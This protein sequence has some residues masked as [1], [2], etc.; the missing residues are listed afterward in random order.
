MAALK[1]NAQY[2]ADVL[3]FSQVQNSTT[4]RFN[5]LGGYKSSLG[6]DINS[7]YGNP[8]GLGMFSKSEFSITPSLKIRN[9]NITIED[10]SKSK[11]SSNI[12]LDNIGVV[13]HAINNKKGN[14]NK[15][16]ISLNFGIGYQKRNAFRNDFQYDLTT[17]ANGLGDFFSETATLENKTQANLNS[18]VNGAAYD[19]FLIEADATDA[20]IYVPN[21]STNSV[22]NQFIDRTGGS[23]NVDF[24]LGANISNTL[25]VGI[26]LGLSSFKYTSIEKTKELG[27]YRY[28][29]NDFDYDVDYYRNFDTEGSGLDLKLGMILRPISALR[30]GLSFESPTWFNV[31]DSYSE[32]LQNN[33]DDV[34]GTDYYPFDYNLRTPAKLNT[35]ISYFFGNKGFLTADIG[36]VDYSTIKFTST[37]SPTNLSTK[38]AVK[39]NYKNT[40]NYSI[41]GEFKIQPDFSLRL[42][43][44]FSGN[45]YKNLKNSD[46]EIEAYSAGLGYKFGPY[47]IDMALVNSDQ[48][49]YYSNYT[50]ANDTE[51]NA[52]IATKT[53]NISLTFGVKF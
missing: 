40:I 41:G 31:V 42:G 13:F 43:Y 28:N 21:T 12:D 2:L 37:D 4:A 49:L 38:T 3:R 15:G 27:L 8:A 10:K 18:L 20:T 23:S 39:Q 46:F 14:L 51:P 11:N 26:N 34:A 5:A 44:Q 47:Y 30:I 52:K 45:P 25:F 48:N 6:G 50:L 35:G 17:N 1:S 29:N 33:I 22:Q 53:N 16:L 36:F 19:S 24:S 32:Q 7:L 9:N